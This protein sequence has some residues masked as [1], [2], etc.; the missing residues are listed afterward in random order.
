MTIA[1]DYIWVLPVAIGV[2]GVYCFARMD[3]VSEASTVLPKA[4][5]KG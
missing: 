5:T 2:V 4:K 3:L 1:L